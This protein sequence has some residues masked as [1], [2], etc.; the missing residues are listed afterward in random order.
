[1]QRLSHDQTQVSMAG[2]FFTP[3]VRD[4]GLF[5]AVDVDAVPALAALAH[6]VS[7]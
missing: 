7:L 5:P 6:K 4:G 3:F 1:M 2:L